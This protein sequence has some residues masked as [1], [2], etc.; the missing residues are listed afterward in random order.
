M[1]LNDYLD[2]EGLP[3]FISCINWIPGM[4]HQE[5]ETLP[6]STEKEVNLGSLFGT[7]KTNQMLSEIWLTQL[8]WRRNNWRTLLEILYPNHNDCDPDSGFEGLGSLF[9][10][11][12]NE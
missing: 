11:E 3:T 8:R 4:V 7:P 12:T 9:G 5:I 6:K 2:G 10:S 1:S